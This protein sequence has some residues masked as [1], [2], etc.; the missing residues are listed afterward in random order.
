MSP[1]TAGRTKHPR[2]VCPKTSW[3]TVLLMLV[4]R[5][6]SC[7]RL[8]SFLG[9]CTVFVAWCGVRVYVFVLALPERSEADVCTALKRVLDGIVSDAA[10]QFLPLRS[11]PFF[12][13]VTHAQGFLDSTEA[14]HGRLST[15]PT[16][17]P[18][19]TDR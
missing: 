1:Q 9:A 16:G 7:N 11:L 5:V 15:L 8:A 4:C 18:G 19:R 6:Q 14:E 3:Y 12:Y 10:P 13:F 2:C 17:P